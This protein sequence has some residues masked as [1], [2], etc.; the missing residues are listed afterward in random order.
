MADITMCTGEGCEAKFTC[1]RFTAIRHERQSF[2]VNSPIKDGSCEY[3]WK[4]NYQV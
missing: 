4:K 2:F 3:Y 1:Y